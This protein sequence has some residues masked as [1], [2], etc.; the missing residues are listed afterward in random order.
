M[1]KMWLENNFPHLTHSTST[2]RVGGWGMSGN[3]GWQN[4]N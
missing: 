4:K 3:G 1:I 2:S